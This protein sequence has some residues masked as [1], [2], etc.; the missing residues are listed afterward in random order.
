MEEIQN[1]KNEKRRMVSILKLDLW[2]YMPAV[3]WSICFIFGTVLQQERII[4]E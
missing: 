4:K 3:Y 2:L 1:F